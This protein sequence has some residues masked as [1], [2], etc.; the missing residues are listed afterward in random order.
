MKHFFLAACIS[1]SLSAG[2][3]T[4]PY[5]IIPQWY[6]LYMANR[7]SP[8]NPYYRFND[9]TATVGGRY[10]TDPIN[11]Y[12]FPFDTLHTHLFEVEAMPAD[13]FPQP[14]MTPTVAAH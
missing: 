13:S 12:Y 1:A 14:V 9:T 5:V 6:A 10:V 4:S 2:A 8:V 7:T 11:V 3:Q